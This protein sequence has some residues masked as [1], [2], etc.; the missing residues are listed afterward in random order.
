MDALAIA[1]LVALLVAGVV[2]LRREAFR[3]RTEYAPALVAGPN[4][5]PWVSQIPY[6][7]AEYPLRTT[8]APQGPHIFVRS[9]FVAPTAMPLVQIP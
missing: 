5:T 8:N 6:P 9:R 1:L 2:Q 4:P 3:F 7:V